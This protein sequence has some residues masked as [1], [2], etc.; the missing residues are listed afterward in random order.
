MNDPHPP[1]HVPVREQ[2]A[3]DF[4]DLQFTKVNPTALTTGPLVWI[5][6][7]ATTCL[8]LFVFHQL[9][10]LVV[11][12]LLALILFYLLFPLMLRLI[13]LGLRRD[14]AA[15]IVSGSFLAVSLGVVV[16]ALP[17]VALRLNDQQALI[18]RYVNGGGL[19]LLQS[20]GALE[21]RFSLLAQAHISRTL[22]ERLQQMAGTIAEQAE[23]ILIGAA[24][25]GPSLLL[26]PVLAYFFLRDGRYFTSFLSRAVPNAFFETTL[27]LL[28]EI[29][30]AARSYF[31]GLIRLT[32]LDT[33]TLALGLWAIGMPMPLL[34][35]LIAAVLAWI[36]YVGSILGGLLVVLV[37]ATDFPSDPS[38]AYW[39][40]GLFIAVRM[41]DDFIYMPMTIGKNL[42]LHPLVTVL[43]V[44]IGGAVAGIPGLMLVLPVLGVVL[45][46]GKTIGVMLTNP[47]LIARY[48]H[49]RALRRKAASNDLKI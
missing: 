28:H 46:I 2:E 37:A 41:L 43:M 39:S 30:Q 35:G 1:E 49:G 21:D 4:R 6:V 20:F 25:W 31:Q 12:F 26:V 47:R 8:L 3:T 27:Y 40:V 19:L 33:I 18:Q 10:W 9:L 45:V 7:I 29:D 42:R 34:L 23:P 22:G 32:I 38:I 13:L 15:L 16:V 14:T 17:W 36:P 48:R 24:A 44:L 5:S 11:P